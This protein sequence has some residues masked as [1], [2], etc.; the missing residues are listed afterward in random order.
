MLLLPSY[1]FIT[2]CHS[3]H[4]FTHIQPF[5]LFIITRKFAQITPFLITFT[6]HSYSEGD[7]INF[8][9]WKCMWLELWLELLQLLFSW[10][11]CKWNKFWS[12]S[13]FKVQIFFI[14]C[15]ICLSVWYLWYRSAF[16]CATS[17]SQFNSSDCLLRSSCRRFIPFLAHSVQNVLYSQQEMNNKQHLPFLLAYLLNLPTAV[18]ERR[19]PSCPII[20]CPLTHPSPF[21]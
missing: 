6:R 12:G 18:R 9:F 17:Y 1:N 15:W 13:W 14:L 19:N 5:S 21:S 3:S 20:E 4:I 2:F 8:S 16:E 11:R 7:F 10:Y